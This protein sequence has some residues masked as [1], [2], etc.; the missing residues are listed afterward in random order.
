MSMHKV[1]LCTY[2]WN[3]QFEANRRQGYLPTNS[4][5]NGSPHMDIMNYECIN[6][7]GLWRHEWR[8]ITFT[9]VVDDFG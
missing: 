6:T 9:L 2:G 1:V 4:S 8:P 7:P 5:E 3:A